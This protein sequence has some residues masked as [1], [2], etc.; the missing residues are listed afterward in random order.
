MIEFETGLA[1]T[2]AW[3]RDNESWWRPLKAEPAHNSAR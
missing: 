1:D 2:L 3:Y